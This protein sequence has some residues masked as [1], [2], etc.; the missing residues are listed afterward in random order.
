METG[1]CTN[2]IEGQWNGLKYHVHPK[3]RA[4]FLEDHLE[5]DIWFS[6]NYDDI[7]KGLMRAL[8]S[9]KYSSGKGAGEYDLD[10][11][12]QEDLL[13][14]RIASVEAKLDAA[15]LKHKA[16]AEKLTATITSLTRDLASL[17]ITAPPLSTKTEKPRSGGCGWCD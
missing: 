4:T 13:R 1:A 14:E 5:V 10:L 11:E 16:T 15:E 12:A 9:I 17:K 2:T 8:S 7:Y 6:Q 3:S